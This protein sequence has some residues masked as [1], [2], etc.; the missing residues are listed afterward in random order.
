MGAEPCMPPGTA[1]CAR[2]LYLPGVGHCHLCPWAPQGIHSS[3]GSDH[4]SSLL[5]PSD[6][7]RALQEGPGPSS[8]HSSL[9]Q[10]APKIPSSGPTE[11]ERVSPIPTPALL[12]ERRE[13]TF[14][15]HTLHPVG[16][17]G[18]SQ[19]PS[20]SNLMTQQVPFTT[21]SW[22]HETTRDGVSGKGGLGGGGVNICIKGKN[23]KCLPVGEGQYLFV[24]NSKC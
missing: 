5:V 6:T 9:P 12:R 13:T 18:L 3:T 8:H 17:V 2:P 10:A 16:E 24:V 14:T 1:F 11:S 23:K 22:P 20:M 7:G 19:V 4:C 15:D 21:A